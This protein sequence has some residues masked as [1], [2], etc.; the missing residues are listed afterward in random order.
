L[1]MTLLRA[2]F[3]A[4]VILAITGAAR[5][6]GP[7]WAGLFS[8]FPITMLPLLAIIQFTYRPAHGRTVIKNVPRGLGALLTYCLAVAAAYENLGVAWGTI[9]GYLVATIYLVILAYRR[10]AIGDGE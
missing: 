5:M 8:A 3:A 4:L 10:R 9:L 7:G 2:V 6:V 1:G